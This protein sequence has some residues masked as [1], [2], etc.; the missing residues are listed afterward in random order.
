MRAPSKYPAIPRLDRALITQVSMELSALFRK[1]SRS[2][3]DI[4]TVPIRTAY[5]VANRAIYVM[6]QE[7]LELCLKSQS[8]FRVDVVI[9]DEAHSI[10]EGARGIILQSVIEDLLARN[11]AAQ[12]LF[13]SPTTRNLETFGRLF[14]LVRLQTHF[15]QEPTVSQN[16]LITNCADRRS[17][18]LSITAA[19]GNGRTTNLGEVSTSLSLRTRI[20]KLAHVPL[21]LC[22][23][24]Q[25]LIYANG[26]DE[27]EDVALLLSKRIGF[28]E[29][30]PRLLAL[31]RLA[32]DS[33][34][35]KCV[36]ADCLLKRVA[37]HYA[38]I[39][40][41]LRQEIESAFSDGEL[42]YLVCTSTLL[43]GV[44]LPA[45][46]IFMFNRL[47]A[48]EILSNRRI[49]GIW[50]GELVVSV[51]NSKATFFLLTIRAG[52]LGLSP[53]RRTPTYHQQ[54][55]RRLSSPVSNSKV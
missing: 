32:K 41:K 53:D 2:M 3:P 23:E 22:A 10:S 28:T 49:S 43:Q 40:T 7:R 5:D 8:A 51:E 17:G 35:Q 4:V 1:H 15:S 50:P 29:P 25:N 39:P 18:R 21:S 27:A 12:I 31:C 16:F 19:R 45:K 13:A 24:Q 26:A 47:R 42:K 9:V 14:N 34:H 20:E 54:S 52:R 44:N 36:L 46:N 37:F 55:K 30:S 38:N 48:E 33:V 11:P 6:T